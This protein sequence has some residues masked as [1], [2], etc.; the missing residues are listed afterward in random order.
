MSGV[1]F[2]QGRG[3]A[4]HSLYLAGGVSLATLRLKHQQRQVGHGC[5]LQMPE[6][7]GVDAELAGKPAAGGGGGEQR[8]IFVR[9]K[10]PHLHGPSTRCTEPCTSHLL[11]ILNLIIFLKEAAPPSRKRNK[12]QVPP[13]LNPPLGDGAWMERGGSGSKKQGSVF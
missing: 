6:L 8:W 11:C 2:F 5:P 9:S 4:E 10:A 3:A 12:L 13:N 1:E 7:G